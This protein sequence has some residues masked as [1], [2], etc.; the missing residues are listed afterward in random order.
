MP[1]FKWE[2]PPE[3][4]NK[5]LNFKLIIARDEGL[6]DIVYT[7]E[8]KA[9]RQGFIP[10]TPVKPG[11]G[12]EF[13]QMF[14]TLEVNQDYYWKVWAWNGDEYYIESPV[15]SFTIQQPIFD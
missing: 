2:I 13:F 3:P 9:Q 4:D 12:H 10:L 1:V 8:S 5:Y 15:W 7:F 14:Q 6:T 11:R